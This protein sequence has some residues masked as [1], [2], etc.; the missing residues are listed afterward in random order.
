MAKSIH[1]DALIVDSLIVSD[2]GPD[3]FQSL[4]RGGL[5]A[6]NATCAVW[7]NFRQT[8]ENI[9]QWHQW[10]AQYGDLIVPVRHTDDILAAKQAGKVGVISG[11]PERQPVRGP[12][13]LRASLQ[14]DGR[15]CR[16]DHLQQ[17][18]PHR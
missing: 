1:Q 6:I 13:G 12:P 3:V 15:R 16:P 11:V 10:F 4:Q 9:A 17:P 7:E 2:W 5:T 18:E 14:V 8:A